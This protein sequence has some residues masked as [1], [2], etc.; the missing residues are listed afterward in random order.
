MKR[1]LHLGLFLLVVGT[2]GL[3][4]KDKE[5]KEKRREEKQREKAEKAEAAAPASAPTAE[6]M[7]KS[8]G[9]EAFRNVRTK[10]IFDP[11]RRGPKLETPAGS[12]TTTSASRGGR[13]LALTGTM[14]TEAKALAFFSG[15]A[16]EGNRVV[17]V[18]NSVANM[19]VTAIRPTQVSLEHE[20]KTIALDVGRQISFDAASG[21]SGAASPIVE[22][23]SHPPAETTGL[24][25]LPGVS[26]DKADI[27]KRMMERRAKEGGR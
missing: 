21:E 19:K 23:A 16:A 8:D 1:F 24:P 25:S 12:A 7:A 9:Y 26:S 5:E 18:G 11:T 6:P 27:L 13:A 22:A 14:V 10:N 3:A 2:T 20:G 17:S 15:S 4:A